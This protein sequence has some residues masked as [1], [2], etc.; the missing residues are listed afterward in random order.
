VAERELD[1]VVWGAT[2]FTGK[3]VAAYLAEHR[4]EGLRWAIAGRDERKLQ[5]VRD[6][7]ARIDAQLGELPILLAD[8]HDRATLDALASKTKAV[9]STVGPFAKH[10]SDLVAACVEQGTHYCDITGESHWVRR[11]IDAHHEAARAAGTRIVTCCGF[12]SIPSDLGCQLLQTEAIERHGAPCSEVTLYV[13]R[14]KGGMSGG[15]LASMANLLD[16]AGRDRSVRKVVGH[17][18]GLN[19]EGERKGPDGPDAHGVARAPDGGWTAPFVM[20]AI[21]TRIVRRTN[22][23]LDYRYGREFRYGE[24]MRFPPGPKGLMMATSLTAGLA[25]FTTMMVARPTRRLLTKRVLP[26]PGQGPSRAERE[27]G[28]WRMRLVGQGTARDVEVLVEGDLDP[29]YGDT[30]KMLG[31]SLLCLALDDLGSEGGVLTPASAMGAPL[32]QRLV[33]AG[34]RFMAQ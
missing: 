8:S 9:S 1:I 28:F 7:L 31:E 5:A 32:R 23:L 11:M 18:Y 26:K 22:A 17:P 15:T 10:G 24:L 12:D 6:E 25:A 29:G 20:A 21:N 27:A 14:V 13:D 4:P 19:P 34:M 3:L 16:E 2:G 33:A 30:A